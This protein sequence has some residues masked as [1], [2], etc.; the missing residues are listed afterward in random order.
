MIP[1]ENKIAAISSGVAERVS[2]Q[3]QLTFTRGLHI[4]TLT[5]TSLS[6]RH[7]HH[8]TPSVSAEVVT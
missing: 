1:F 2:A 6:H 3:Y 8:H 4:L 5:M 7:H